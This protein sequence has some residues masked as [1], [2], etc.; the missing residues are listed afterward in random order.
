MI[1]IKNHSGIY[2][3][4]TEQ[5][6]PISLV[7]AWNFFSTPVN[8]QKITPGNMSF[9]ITSGDVQSMHPGQIISY[10]VGILPLLKSS[11]VTEITHIRD[12]KYFVDE[13]RF[14]PYKMW[15]HEHHFEQRNGGVMMR[16]KVSYKIPFGIVGRMAHAIFI[17]SQLM[18]IFSY[19][20][21]IL[22]QMFSRKAS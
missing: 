1:E 20:F 19:R 22:T 2:T 9:K 3:L 6:L 18:K 11:W 17:K 15:H 8:L 14:G 12:Q 13:Q 4:T 5:F 16:D 21:E 10:K 7:E